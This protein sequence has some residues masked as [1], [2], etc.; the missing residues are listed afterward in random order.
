MIL[1]KEDLKNVL[2]KP[3]FSIIKQYQ[4]LF[5]FDGVDPEFR[6][7]SIDTIVEKCIK[8]KIGARGLRKILDE[9]LLETQYDLPEYKDK[10]TSEGG[11]N[12]KTQ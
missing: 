10:G 9:T 6:Q 4:A 8:Q 11:S 7:D 12:L 2:T 3:K 5:K 1:S